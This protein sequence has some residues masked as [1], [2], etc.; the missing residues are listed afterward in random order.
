[1]TTS[2]ALS[3]P[4][5]CD[6]DLT[7]LIGIYHDRKR[8]EG[9]LSRLRTHFPQARVIV[10]SDGDVD[11]KNR[12]LLARFDVDYREEERLYP[13]ENGG[14]MIA[15][16]LSLFLEK[17]TRYLL[18]MDSDIAI[19]RRFKFLPKEPEGGKLEPHG[20]LPKTWAA[21]EEL[22]VGAV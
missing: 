20:P 19:Y 1:M 15:R 7:F 17:P 8:A 22:A 3:A 14:A 16:M 12:E 13:I 5:Y 18:K 11:P 4:N 2:D 6:D 10:R 21:F 9:A